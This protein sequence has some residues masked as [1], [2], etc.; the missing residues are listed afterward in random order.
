MDPNWNYD[1]GLMCDQSL[2]EGVGLLASQ[3]SSSG[4]RRPNPSSLLF[5]ISFILGI[6]PISFKQNLRCSWARMPNNQSIIWARNASRPHCLSS[7]PVLSIMKWRIHVQGSNSNYD[8]VILRVE[9]V[10]SGFRPR[11]LLFYRARA[12]HRDFKTLGVDLIAFFAR[13]IMPAIL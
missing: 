11:Y 9:G 6:Q 2:R 4:A 1:K 13:L 8:A 5:F 7:L 3:S 10:L 12:C